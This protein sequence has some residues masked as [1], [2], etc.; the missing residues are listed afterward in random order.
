[1]ENSNE[2]S[3]EKKTISNK[4]LYSENMSEKTEDEII[5]NN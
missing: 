3:L 1:M 5:F 4:D 2:E